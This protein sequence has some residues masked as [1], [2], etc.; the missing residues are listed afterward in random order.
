M[1]RVKSCITASPRSSDSFEPGT[2]PSRNRSVELTLIESPFRFLENE[3]GVPRRKFACGLRGIVGTPFRLSTR[4]I[5]H[6]PHD[7]V[8]CDD[9][10]AGTY[11][12]RIGLEFLHDVSLGMTR[13]QN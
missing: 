9:I 8:R 12:R 11:Q 6:Q 10:R 7:P 5:M 3:L 13:I 1:T 4:R 2:W